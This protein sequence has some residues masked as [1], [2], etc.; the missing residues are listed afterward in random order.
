MSAQVED[1]AIDKEFEWQY[2]LPVFDEVVSHVS[3]GRDGTTMAVRGAGY[4][5]T[6]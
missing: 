6:L 5:E 1:V 3:I 4:R 2:E